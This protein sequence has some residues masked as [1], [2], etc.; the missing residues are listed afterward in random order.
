MQMAS[1]EIGGLPF[2]PLAFKK[3]FHV[4]LSIVLRVAAMKLHNA[5]GKYAVAVRT[6]YFRALALALDKLF[7]DFCVF[8]F[9]WDCIRP[10]LGAEL[11]IPVFRQRDGEMGRRAKNDA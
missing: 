1:A 3:N 2:I 7:D 5:V 8:D 6:A 4:E 10:S 9:E 11:R